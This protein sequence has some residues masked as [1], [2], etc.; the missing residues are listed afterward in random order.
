VIPA[1]LLTSKGLVK[2]QKF[3]N[4][5]YIGDPINAIRIFNEKEV[6]EL[7]VLD[8]EASKKNQLPNYKLIEEFASECFMPLCYG[9]EIKTVDQAE[10][11]FALGVEK[12][13]LQTSALLD[14]DFVSELAKKFGSQSVVI[15]LDVKKDPTGGFNV[16][17]MTTNFVWTPE[18][19]SEKHIEGQG[20]AHVYLANQKII[21]LY[22]NWFHLNTFQFATTLGEQLLRVELVGNDHAPITVN[23]Q[24][25]SSELLVDVPSDEIRPQGSNAWKLGA[26]GAASIAFALGAI[27]FFSYV[28]RNG[29]KA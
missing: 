24:S 17:V 15:S 23:A 11:I 16:K 21:R 20:H 27:L 25:I 5:K 6:D 29:S 18:S 9:G 2:T 10:K 1:L 4:P 12:I 19:A 13:C 3:E 7:I 8:I 22:N 26:I 14:L 28:K